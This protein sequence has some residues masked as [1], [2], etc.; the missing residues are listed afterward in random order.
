MPPP[1]APPLKRVQE[2]ADELRL[3]EEELIPYGHYKG[4]IAPA[5]LDRLRDRPHRRTGLNTGV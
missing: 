3:R 5:A 4:K 1:A 2:L